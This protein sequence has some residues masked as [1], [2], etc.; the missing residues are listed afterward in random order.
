[1]YQCYRALVRAKVAA[2]RLGQPALGP[3]ERGALEAEMAGYL[4]LAAAY[5]LP[6]RN[7]LLITQGPSGSGKSRAAAL[8][9]QG[10]PA[11]R[12][13]SDVERKRLAGLSP[14]VRSQSG[15]GE[16]IYGPDATRATYGH[17]LHLA[18][19]ILAAGYNLVVDATFLRREQ[20][21]P[22]RELAACLGVPFAILEM[23]T[24]EAEMRRRIRARLEKGRDPSE[25]DEGVLQRQLAT[26]EPLDEAERRLALPVLPDAPLP[27]DRLQALL[28]EDAEGTGGPG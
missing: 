20:R 12:I 22:F 26:L 17:L 11:L 14:Q 28:G 19:L 18:E 3:G 27:L 16:G 1:L 8:L 4:R 5:T 13:R 7:L 6:R 2:L 15:L 10:L 23:R 24:P 25:A 9:A 21:R